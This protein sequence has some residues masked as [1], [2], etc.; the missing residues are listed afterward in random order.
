LTDSDESTKFNNVKSAQQGSSKEV[1]DPSPEHQYSDNNELINNNEIEVTELDKKA[2][3]IA[4]PN[5]QKDR[6]LSVIET[7]IPLEKPK[8]G[9]VAKAPK[10]KINPTID[11][12]D[13]PKEAP[14]ETNV[15]RVQNT[16]DVDDQN[17]LVKSNL[18]TVQIFENEFLEKFLLEAYSV[19]KRKCD[20]W[21]ELMK[22]FF[23]DK[24]EIISVKKLMNQFKIKKFS[25]NNMFD[26]KDEINL[27]HDFFKNHN[28]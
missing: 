10:K 8:K 21:L 22:N 1:S 13:S 18:I 19:N 23:P 27:L 6:H 9:K 11:T 4:N 24:N 12:S 17:P 26:S 20:L 15:S 5:E 14:L 16:E 28:Q 3:I 2:E 7:D 25:Q